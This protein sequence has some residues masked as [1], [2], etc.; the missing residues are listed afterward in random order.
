MPPD[1]ETRTRSWSP[2]LIVV[3]VA[4]GTVLSTS[5]GIRQSLGLFLGSIA[6]GTGIS[7]ATF[8]LAMAVQN[9]ARGIGQPFMGG[10]A[11]RFGGQLV[12]IIGAVCF[13]L[14]LWLMSLG[15]VFG[16]F[17]GGVVLIGFAVAATSHGV[18]VGIISRIAAPQVRALAVSILA[19][20]GSLG[21]FIIAPGTQCSLNTFYR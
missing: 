14:G 15:T 21:T 12:I 5:L 1:Q 13:T 17:L 4:A 16:I 7:I 8:G 9:L 10:L 18:L 11:D 3:L 2:L 20:V 6:Y 19:A